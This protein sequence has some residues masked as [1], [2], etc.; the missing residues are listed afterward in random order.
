MP[1]IALG[2]TVAVARGA[3]HNPGPRP[4]ARRESIGTRNPVA[5]APASRDPP[6]P[7]K[8]SESPHVSALRTRVHPTAIIQPGAELGEGVE[9]GPWCTVGQRVR[10]GEG[11]RLH[12]HVVLDGDTVVGP[13]T[14]L[15]P[16]VVLGVRPQDKKLRANAEELREKGWFDGEG[17]WCGKLRIGADNEIRES[18]TIHG[19]TPY[20]RGITTVGDRNMFLAGSHVGHDAEVGSDCIFTNGAM[21]AGHARIADRVILG[22]MAGVHQFARIGRF[23]ML[24]GGSMLSQDAPPFALVQGDRARLISVNTIGLKRS[25][26]AVEQVALIK[27]VYR[28]LFWREGRLEDRIAEARAFGRGDPLAEEILAFVESSERGVCSPRDRSSSPADDSESR[29]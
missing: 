19:G 23:V 9:V 26:F 20:G 2:S 10:V 25:G 15:F 29:T 7:L 16:F 8:P 12:S 22:G 18:V 14:E 11:C 28:M 1:T 17:N 27:R 3:A 4:D 21:A 13:R 5:H 24:G 6:P